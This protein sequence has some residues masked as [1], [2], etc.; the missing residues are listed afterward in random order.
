MTNAQEAY[1]RSN[2][3]KLKDIKAAVDPYDVFHTR[4]SVNGVKP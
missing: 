1:W 3:P 4:Q 2:L